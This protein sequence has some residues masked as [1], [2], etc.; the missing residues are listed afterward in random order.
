MQSSLFFWVRCLSLLAKWGLFSILPAGDLFSRLLWNGRF[1][2][3]VQLL[4]S[5]F[6]DSDGSI[7]AYYW[8]Y[9][10]CATQQAAFKTVT[11]DLVSA[12]RGGHAGTRYSLSEPTR[13]RLNWFLSLSL[14]FSPSHSLSLFYQFLT[15]MCALWALSGWKK[16]S[17]VFL[18]EELMHHMWGENPQLLLWV[19]K[20]QLANS[21]S[22]P[23]APPAARSKTEASHLLCIN[24]TPYAHQSVPL[25]NQKKKKVPVVCKLSQQVI[26]LSNDLEN[27]EIYVLSLMW[28]LG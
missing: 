26:L 13:M 5:H 22:G 2:Y 12:Q 25:P 21:V 11:P 27:S 17:C 19:H 20:K 4:N 1:S 24:S 23:I 15:V 10:S 16:G 6:C 18:V 9:S 3:I 28:C 8:V 7:A 14:S